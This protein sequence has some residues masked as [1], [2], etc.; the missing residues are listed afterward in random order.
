MCDPEQASQTILW[1]SRTV[2]RRISITGHWQTGWAQGC[3]LSWGTA[4]LFK[5]WRFE[6]ISPFH[7]HH[8]YSQSSWSITSTLLGQ[9]TF[10]NKPSS[11]QKLNQKRGG[12]REVTVGNLYH[13]ILSKPQSD[14]SSTSLS[15]GEDSAWRV[16]CNEGKKRGQSLLIQ[17]P[18]RGFFSKEQAP[19]Y[20][21]NWTLLFNLRSTCTVVWLEK[22]SFSIQS[23]VWLINQEASSPFR[24][25]LTMS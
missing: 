15:V 2:L 11:F 10:A 4:R 8:D 13:L 16:R 14:H 20:L 21:G 3:W 12:Q 6:E 5:H 22:Q 7:K 23:G 24:L 19:H 1:Q 25:F 9:V 18:A 17:I